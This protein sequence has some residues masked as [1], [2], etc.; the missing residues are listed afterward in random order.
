[1]NLVDG[2]DG[3][4]GGEQSL[5]EAVKEARQE[6][7]ETHPYDEVERVEEEPVS[8]EPKEPVQAKPFFKGLAKEV[9][10][11]EELSDYALELEKKLIM[12]E[13]KLTGLGQTLGQPAKAETP[14]APVDTDQDFYAQVAEEFI[15]KPQDA[16]KKI[17]ERIR[18]SILGD[19]EREA[20]KKTFFSSFYEKH[21]DL[22]GCE[23]IVDMVLQRKGP[24][25]A[26][27]PVGQAS[28][29]L[30][31]EVRS[32]LASLR[33]SVNT[34]NQTQILSSRPAHALGSSGPTP[35]KAPAAKVE[36]IG[37]LVSD[38][39]GFQAKRKK[40]A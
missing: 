8:E 34:G 9:A 36:T 17:E 7:E 37:T 24:E 5:A 20:G 4:Q 28:E 25:W 2:K 12:Q 6:A 3:E 38:L 15:L 21:E 40:R 26:N 13:A 23:D 11:A 10:T 31:N 18:K 33:G 27:V 14:T 22:K 1:M 30:A 19:V 16:V 39:K 35:P 32:R 29:L